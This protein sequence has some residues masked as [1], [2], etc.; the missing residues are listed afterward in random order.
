MSAELPIAR[1]QAPATNGTKSIQLIDLVVFSKF[2]T[3]AAL[4]DIDNC[5]GA[6]TSTVPLNI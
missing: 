6:G 5:H 4:D 2:S 3:I 1:M